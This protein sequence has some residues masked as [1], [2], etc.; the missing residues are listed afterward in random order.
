MIDRSRD[1]QI[2]SNMIANYTLR[3]M[4]MD[5]TKKR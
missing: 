3:K 4:P 5:E 2:S 1:I